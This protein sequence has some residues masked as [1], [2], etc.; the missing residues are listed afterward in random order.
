M[1]N[2]WIGRRSPKCV[3]VWYRLDNDYRTAFV[4]YKH[5]MS[6]RDVIRFHNEITSH[7]WPDGN[8]SGVYDRVVHDGNA[9]LLSGN[10]KIVCPSAYKNG[11]CEFSLY[12]GGRWTLRMNRYYV[13]I[14]D[15]LK[16]HV[17]VGGSVSY[18]T[19]E[20]GTTVTFVNGTDNKV[21]HG[22]VVAP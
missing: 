3:E 4:E 20:N 8:S 6:E 12:L 17:F 16:K 7:Y 10:G 13:S 15:S 21:Y 9:F 19:G 18:P 5:V 1:K 11:H 22:A 14:D 2:H